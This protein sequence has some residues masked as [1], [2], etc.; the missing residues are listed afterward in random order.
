MIPGES[1]LHE[2]PLL[3]DKYWW[4]NTLKYVIGYPLNKALTMN[5]RSSLSKKKSAVL[6]YQNSF[7]I[8]GKQA[9]KKA[10]FFISGPESRGVISSGTFCA[11]TLRLKVKSVLPFSSCKNP[12]WSRGAI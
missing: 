3:F 2:V 7:Q 12:I 6:D 9:Y 4:K 8:Q 11:S 5:Y 1:P 10:Q